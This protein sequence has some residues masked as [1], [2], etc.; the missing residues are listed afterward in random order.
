ML[1]LFKNSLFFDSKVKERRQV[2]IEEQIGKIN[3]LEETAKHN[4]EELTKL[5][6]KHT[7]E[8]KKLDDEIKK[9]DREINKRDESI[10]KL[11]DAFSAKK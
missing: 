11:H 4:V 1:L 3:K 5:N 6:D 2:I 10:Q 7:A 8:L 9:R